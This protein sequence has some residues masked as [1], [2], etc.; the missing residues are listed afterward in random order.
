MAARGSGGRHHRLSGILTG[1]LAVVVAG[2]PAWHAG[3]LLIVQRE[4]PNPQALLVLASHEW[5]RLPAVADLAHQFP[6]ALVLLT[7][8]VE[9][10]PEN[11]HRCAER[12][13]WLSALG[14]TRQRVHVLPDRGTNTHDEA[15]AA[16]KFCRQKSISRL[17]VVTSPY[18]T[19]RALA[20]FASVFD[21]SI[22]VAVQPATDH[23]PAAPD[24]WWLRSYDRAYVAYEWAAVVWYAVRYGVSPL[25]RA[26]FESS[27]NQTFWALAPLCETREVRH[28]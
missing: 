15:T 8:P 3:R 24:Y 4:L 1:L 7:E 10:T 17:T 13:V 28:G 23:S 19:R 12:V 27:T 9:P 22:T 14:V 6:E 11:C 18:H 5:E 20:T 2:W 21:P 16:L 25:V 26:G